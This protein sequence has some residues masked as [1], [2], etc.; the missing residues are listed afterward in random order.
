V[1]NFK[2]PIFKKQPSYEIP[3]NIEI[4]FVSDMFV[5]EYV[6]GAEL[7]TEAL[8]SSSP[9][10]ILKLKSQNITIDHIK[11]GLNKFWIFGNFAN[12]NPQLIPTIVTY[13]KYSVLEYDYKYCKYRSPEKHQAN[14]GSPCDCHDQMVGKMISAFY[15][16]SMGLWWMSEKQ[17]ERYFTLFPFL[18]EKDNIV[19][20]SVFSNETLA[21][22]RNLNNRNTEFNKRKQR[23]G[24]IVLGSNS[25]VKGA[26]NAE[27]YCIDNKLS[28]EVIWNLPYETVLQKLADAEGFVY[29]PDGSDTCPRMCIEAKLLDCKVIMNDF[30]QHKDE[31]WFA[32]SNLSDIENYLISSPNLF[33]NGIRKMI[34]H[35]HKISGYITTYNCVKQEYPFDKCI[36]SLLGF[37]DEVC[38]VD[39]GSTD[40]TIKILN[41]LALKDSRIK[42][43]VVSRDWSDPRFA[44]FDGMQK[45]EARSMCTG[46][47]CWQ[48]D[49]DEIVHEDDY[50]KV[51]DLCKSFPK[52]VDILSL[53]VIE[54]WGT[55]EK[56]RMDIQPWKWRLS[57]NKN[58]IT[59]GIPFNLRRYDSGGRV[60]S[61]P[62][63]DGCDMID[64]TTGERLNHMGFYTQDADKFRQKGLLSLNNVDRDQYEKWF[65]EMTNILPCVFHYSWLNLPRKI[66]LYRDYWSA[67]W[68]NLVGNDYKDL[69]TTNMMFDVPWTEVTDD[70]INDLAKKLSKTGGHIWHSKWNGQITPW[71]GCSR[72]QPKIME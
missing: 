43:K 53:P 68:E 45:A 12:L 72:K 30:V 26:K 34:D 51:K 8:I 3:D 69:P 27:Q 9:L 7:T 70:M 65:N 59:H 4:I 55:L 15:Y 24:W 11:N 20:S 21:L 35:H 2:E 39:G 1:L 46:D 14:S 19:L 6:G 10:K 56:V 25:W 50:E 52:D 62:G 37:C 71:I 16:G 36:Q 47:F 23:S 29:L 28:Y 67:H 32:T 5:D 57:K 42:I 38:V 33:W 64:K 40:E 61:L 60:Y 48:M 66:K 58:N 63:S 17:Q 18:K 31:E 44:V 13:L 54:F 41:D 49:S 22:L